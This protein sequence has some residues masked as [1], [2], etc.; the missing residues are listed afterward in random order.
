MKT[1]NDYKTMK[2]FEGQGLQGFPNQNSSKGRKKLNP[3]V[4]VAGT[5]GYT[6]QI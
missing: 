4:C 5:T 6:V 2:P 1:K 3:E